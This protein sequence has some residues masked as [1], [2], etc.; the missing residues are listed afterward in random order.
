MSLAIE[1]AARF[2]SLCYGDVAAVIFEEIPNDH[3]QVPRDPSVVRFDHVDI[4][5]VEVIVETVVAAP[6]GGLCQHYAV[7]LHQR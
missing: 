7:R 6:G 3:I 2:S 4:I 5:P 1:L